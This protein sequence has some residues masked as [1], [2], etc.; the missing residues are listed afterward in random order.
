MGSQTSVRFTRYARLALPAILLAATAG[1]TSAAVSPGV[2]CGAPNANGFDKQYYQSCQQWDFSEFSAGTTNSA[3][4]RERVQYCCYRAGGA[5][6]SQAG[7]P[8]NAEGGDCVDPPPFAMPVPSFDEDL[9]RPP[10]P[11]AE[12]EPPQPDFSRLP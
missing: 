7:T 5:F 12:P 9:L 6:S 4:Y 1:L 8:G 3:Q 2:A 11:P 10:P